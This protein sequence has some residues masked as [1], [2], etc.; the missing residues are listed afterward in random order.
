MAHGVADR[1]GATYGVATT[2]VAGPDVQ[3][4]HP[5]G[6]VWIAVSGP[7]QGYAFFDSLDVAPTGRVDVGFQG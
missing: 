2:G 5:V 6:E 4:G 1:L 7:G 3:D